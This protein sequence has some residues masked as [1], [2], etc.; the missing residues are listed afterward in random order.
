[1]KYT[2]VQ[3]SQ[4]D[5]QI[6]KIGL[7][8]SPFGTNV[9]K[10]D[11]FALLDYYISKGGNVVD[12]ARVYAE[13]L[14][15]GKSASEKTIGKWIKKN[16]NRDKIVIMTK[17]GHPPMSNM[18]IS[19][20]SQV[21]IRKDMEE[22]LESLC[23]DQID[24]YFLHRDDTSIPVEKIVDIMDIFVKERKIKAF[25]VSNWKASR[26]IEANEYAKNS[27]KTPISISQI[28]WSYTYSSNEMQNGDGMICMDEK[29][30]ETYKKM[31]IPV[32]AYSSQAKGF[33]QKAYQYGMENI[34]SYLQKY[35]CEE[36]E[37]RLEAV[38]EYMAQGGTSVTSYVLDYI[39]SNQVE[40]VALIGAKN[41]EQ[42]E[43]CLV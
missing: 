41:I 29:E 30:Y 32:V 25:G 5:I 9:S 3:T 11:A 20:I 38:K 28:Q 1:M 39:T 16:N 17:G 13:W 33:M 42:L 22:S 19:R 12:T 2:T 26:I 18:E 21:E 37:V 10:E 8:A 6:S 27:G 15:N 23:V 14:P 36:N 4:G 7:G 35:V 40:A 24:I 34:P 31:K 43:E